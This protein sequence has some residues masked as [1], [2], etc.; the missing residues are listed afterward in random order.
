M[1]FILA[2]SGLMATLS[3]CMAES[4]AVHLDDKSYEQCK[5]V[6]PGKALQLVCIQAYGGEVKPLEARI[7]RLPDG[8]L[9]LNMH[10][11]CDTSKKKH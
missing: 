10:W 3:P 1:R 6:V 7:C 5:D 8:T 2:L 9:I 11:E 4:Y